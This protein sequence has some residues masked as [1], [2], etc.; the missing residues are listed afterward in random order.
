MG[1]LSDWIEQLATKLSP[2]YRKNQSSIELHSA[3]LT[4]LLGITPEFDGTETGLWFYPPD[5]DF[6]SLLAADLPPGQIHDLLGA[7]FS[8][9]M[10]LSDWTSCQIL[11]GDCRL[12][13]REGSYQSFLDRQREGYKKLLGAYL[14]V[15][16]EL[17][18]GPDIHQHVSV[19]ILKRFANKDWINAVVLSDGV[20]PV[21]ELN[22]EFYKIER[23]LLRHAIPLL[24]SVAHSMCLPGYCATA[25]EYLDFIRRPGIRSDVETQLLDM[26]RL[27]GRPELADNFSAE[28]KSIYDSEQQFYLERVIRFVLA[29][30]SAPSQPMPGTLDPGVEALHPLRMIL[31]LWSLMEQYTVL[32]RIDSSFLKDYRW[33]EI[34][35]LLESEQLY[36]ATFQEL[37]RIL[38]AP[39]HALYLARPA[40]RERLKQI[41][42]TMGYHSTTGIDALDRC[43]AHY[44]FAVLRISAAA[45]D[46]ARMQLRFLANHGSM[47]KLSREPTS[48]VASGIAS[49]IL[50]A[51]NF[52]GA[53]VIW[54]DLVSSE[55]PQQSLF[56]AL[57][58]QLAQ[59]PT[60]EGKAAENQLIRFVSASLADA[61]HVGMT[62]TETNRPA[63][64]NCLT[65]VQQRLV[66][67][68]IRDL[69][70]VYNQEPGLLWRFLA[71]AEPATALELSQRL[72][73]RSSD[74]IE[75][76]RNVCLLF[77]YGSPFLLRF[78]RRVSLIETRDI[79]RLADLHRLEQMALSMLARAYHAANRE[80]WRIALGHFFDLEFTR[81]AVMLFRR[82]NMSDVDQVYTNFSDRF[83]RTMFSLSK[84]EIEQRR[85]LPRLDMAKILLYIA[86]GHA[87]NQS[88]TDDYDLIS[89]MVNPSDREE[90]ANV[91]AMIG[92]F[93][94]ELNRKGIWAHHR[95][96][97]F[98]ETYVMSLEELAELLTNNH[99][100]D[101]I[102]KS[103]ILG[104]RL[105]IGSP[106]A[107]QRFHD[108]ILK[109]LVYDQAREYIRDLRAE[110]FDRHSTLNDEFMELNIKECPG[111][112][113]DIELGF[114]AGKALTQIA[115]PITAEFPQ[116]LA[117]VLPQCAKLILQLGDALN[118]LKLM[119]SLIRLTVGTSDDIDAEWLTP[120][121]LLMGYSGSDGVS[122][123]MHDFSETTAR[124]RILVR[125]LFDELIRM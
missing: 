63:G 85:N 37:V 58:E 7:Y 5:K 104:C 17:R 25:G 19:L 54:T 52:F 76:L 98:T 42:S 59:Q 36:F 45:N 106:G 12:G 95:F 22:R 32:H 14:S 66:N 65:F 88:F 38:L 23:E 13:I 83:L 91:S 48:E 40:T 111:G 47:H 84:A 53:E 97:E 121:A 62:Q 90:L 10:L 103:Q 122:H 57:M 120:V 94:Q 16:L 4:K 24:F 30:L 69:V 50:E 71:E 21:Q 55:A 27:T 82:R 18:F 79:P 3:T 77:S 11:S 114:M 117:R 20:I 15:L 113:R 9:R 107:D 28:L 49:G 115:N 44:H 29:S 78:I 87:R 46:V 96:A 34:R 93:S 86:G 51:A 56:D 68:S 89:I 60:A 6:Q 33:M 70:A 109:P 99:D 100:H 102:E 112:L 26:E 72:N 1:I 116:L 8:L 118:F 64:S 73:E 80:E 123:L 74:S 61:L 110:I 125:E 124:T 39:H 2:Y 35:S 41:A 108:T 43:L 81:A 92:A 75:A 105:V 101:F 67:S 119:R 31:V